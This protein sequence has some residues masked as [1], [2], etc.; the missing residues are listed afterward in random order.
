MKT[1]LFSK[2]AVFFALTLTACALPAQKSK[3]AE[4]ST[5]EA[6]QP[7]SVHKHQYGEW[8][9]VKAPT[10]TEK[11]TQERVCECGDKQTKEVAA[12]NHD[13][14]EGTVTKEATCSVPGEKT[15]H[16]KRDGCNETKVEQI[17]AAHDLQAIAH[18]KGEGE[19]TEVISKC[20]KD[21][22][23]QI[24]FDAFDAAAVLNNSSDRKSNYVKLSKQ[25]AADGTGTASYI[26]W[27]IYSPLALRGRFWID[28]TGNTSNIWDRE[29]ESGAQALY[30]TY[31]DTTTNI[32]TWK[33]KVELNETE[34]DFENATYNVKGEEIPFAKLLYSDF[35]ELASS[36]GETISVPMPEVNLVEGVNT[37]RF[38]RLTGYA[39]N[40]HKFTFK[41]SL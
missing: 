40:M 37:L 11:G 17:L 16:C 7:Q 21:N 28:I 25:V 15:Y 39:F 41:T 8:V 18:E 14:D 3:D 32:N 27:K 38:T 1:K 4:A 20:N 19:V 13:W 22:Y 26:E 36:S 9:T 24:E 5:P 12:L 30:Y 35:G 2:I 23:Y 31:N 34:V 6:S 10:C 29:T 33:N